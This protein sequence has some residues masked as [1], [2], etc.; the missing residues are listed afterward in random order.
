MG[1]IFQFLYCRLI[2]K[3]ANDGT[4]IALPAE[5]VCQGIK[6]YV[7]D[8][9]WQKSG[10]K[11]LLFFDICKLIKS[12]AE[13]MAFFGF[14]FPCRVGRNAISYLDAEGERTARGDE[15]FVLAVG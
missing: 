11:L 2:A 14:L 10:A 7:R 12:C 6:I 13:T 9:S 1:Y 5:E 8:I 3:P 4:D 15:A